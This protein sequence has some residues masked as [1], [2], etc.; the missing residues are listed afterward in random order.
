MAGIVV[1]VGSSVQKFKVGDKV[2][3]GVIHDCCMECEMCKEGEEQYC[4]KG[5]V[6]AYDSGKNKSYGSHI[7]GNLEVHT[8]G[9]YSGSVV[10]HERFVLKIPDSMPLE[11]VGPLLC[12]GITVY[13][14]LR[15]WGATTGKPMTIGVAGIGGLGTMGIKLAKSLG[16][17]VV[18]ISSTAQKEALAKEKGADSFVVST[19]WKSMNAE[20][21][22]I[23]IILNT[24]SAKHS[25]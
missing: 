24:I 4:E 8:L 9:G 20:E 12:A 14:P 3:V 18:A 23:D 13:D 17:R 10:L 5:M 7:G 15:Q 16:H 25:I 11:K 2:G 1:E 22:K 6:E 21:G 19:E